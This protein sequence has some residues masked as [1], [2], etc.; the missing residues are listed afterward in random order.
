MLKYSV[1]I[2]HIRDN[3]RASCSRVLGHCK[4]REGTSVNTQTHGL[5]VDVGDSHILNLLYTMYSE[6]VIKVRVNV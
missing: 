3:P 2:D 5:Q 4:R 1:V 6:C